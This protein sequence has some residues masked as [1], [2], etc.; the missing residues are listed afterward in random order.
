ME[1]IFGIVELNGEETSTL[2]TIGAEHTDF[3]GYTQIQRAYTDCNI[4]DSFNVVRKFKSDEDAEGN[5]Y[6]WYVISKHSRNI[7]YTPK[8]E[9]VFDALLG[10]NGNLQAAEQTRKILQNYASTFS[11]EQAMEVA[12][13]YEAYEVGRSYAANELF[14]YGENSVGDP[15]LYRVVQAHTSQAD[16]LPSETPALYTPIGVTEEGFP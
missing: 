2:E 9:A 13:I 6:D 12:T 4:T 15:Q 16:W 8:H 11:D 7:D 5:C 10:I 14:T 1:Y 3:V